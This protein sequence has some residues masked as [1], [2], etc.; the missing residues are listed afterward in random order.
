MK[1]YQKFNQRAMV[2]NSRPT[3]TAST[4]NHNSNLA[5]DNSK[6]A[7]LAN[8]SQTHHAQYPTPNAQRPMSMPTQHAALRIAH[9]VHSTT[10]REI[11]GVGR[12]SGR[13]RGYTDHTAIITRGVEK[14]FRTLTLAWMD[15]WV[16]SMK[17]RFFFW[18][19]F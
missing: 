18:F 17:I 5:I 7:T 12:G 14:K 6:L 11:R 9:C 10:R 16:G 13:G 19:F 2:C 15:G 3:A 1:I 4:H 8:R